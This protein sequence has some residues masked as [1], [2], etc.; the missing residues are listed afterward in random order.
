MQID[1][2]FL[3][4]RIFDEEKPE[5]AA[6]SIRSTTWLWKILWMSHPNMEKLKD[7]LKYYLKVKRLKIVFLIPYAWTKL[8]LEESFEKLLGMRPTVMMAPKRSIEI[9]SSAIIKRSFL[10][11]LNIW[12]HFFERSTKRKKLRAKGLD[13][14]LLVRNTQTRT[15]H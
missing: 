2:N 12:R 5:S 10:G 11:L 1:C 3:I 6:I 7:W 9:H 15:D 14:K 13:S 8:L 4:A